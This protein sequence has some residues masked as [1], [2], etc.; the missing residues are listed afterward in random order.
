M[1]GQRQGQGA[2]AANRGQMHPRDR[3][4]WTTRRNSLLSGS[5]VVGSGR[6]ADPDRDGPAS[7]Q[8]GNQ[9]SNRTAL[10]AA[11]SAPPSRM[12]LWTALETKFHKKVS[13]DKRTTR[14]RSW[15][16]GKGSIEQSAEFSDRSGGTATIG[17]RRRV[18]TQ[19]ADL[20]SASEEEIVALSPRVMGADNSSVRQMR[21]HSVGSPNIGGRSSAFSAAANSTE[22]RRQPRRHSIS[23]EGPD[24][25]TLAPTRPERRPSTG[26]E[27][28]TPA[29][30]DG[31]DPATAKRQ[32]RQH[33]I[34]STG[35][36]KGML[37]LVSTT[38]E[39]RLS[40]G[41]E[42]R[43]FDS[44]SE[45]THTGA[46]AVDIAAQRESDVEADLGMYPQRRSRR[47]SIQNTFAR[48]AT[49]HKRSSRRLSLDTATAM[50]NSSPLPN[51]SSPSTPRALPP[52]SVVLTR[53]KSAR[54]ILTGTDGGRNSNYDSTD[55]T[56]DDLKSGSDMGNGGDARPASI[57]RRR[58][59]DARMTKAKSVPNLSEDNKTVKFNKDVVCV[60][61]F[62]AEQ[63]GNATFAL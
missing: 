20:P 45:R 62:Q 24:K 21:R 1:Q 36:G 42:R 34:S 48:V 19:S 29:G 61:I 41:S 23:S 44:A 37:D 27:R 8:D 46:G 56:V 17:R 50:N 58:Q 59:G 40:T 3:K 28:R 15:I 53:S 60:E 47:Q 7:T 14:R 6:R 10:A 26:S 2:A 51:T 52:P 55:D 43:A 25:R 13:A 57:L 30:R 5:S 63:M 35:S 4:A 54:A 11:S 38:P 22:V 31:Q 16:Q 33:S 12:K 32:P 9:K 18:S 49:T 39:R